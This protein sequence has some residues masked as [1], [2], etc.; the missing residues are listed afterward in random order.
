MADI[1]ESVLDKYAAERGKRLRSDQT[2]QYV[3]FRD[4]MLASMDKDPYVD[5]DKLTAEGFP[6][7]DG[8]EVKVLIAGGGML[9]IMTA[10]HLVNQAGIDS[11]D[12]VVVDKAGGFGGTWYW[13]RYPKVACDIESYCYVPLLEETNYMP[14]HRY[15]PGHEIREQLE[16]IARTSNIRGQFCTT[17]ISQSWDDQARRWNINMSRARGSG[18]EPEQLTVD[19]QFLILAG[20]IQTSPHAPKLNGLGVFAQSPGKVLMHTARWDWS[21]SGGSQETPDLTKLEGK[22]VGIVGTGATSVQ[23]APHIAKWAKETY[24]FQRTP[25]YVGPLCQKETTPADWAKVAYKPG[26]QYERMASLDAMFTGQKDAKNIVQDSWTEVSGMVAMAGH[27]GKIITPDDTEA[28]VKEMIDTD[29]PWTESMRRR[30]DEEVHDSETAQKLKAWYPG[31]CK[32]PTFHTEYLSMFNQPNVTL[33]DT[34]GKGITAYTPKGV[35]A[36]DREYELDILVLATGYTVGLVDSTPSSALNATLEGRNGR[37]LKDKWESND[38]GALY[39]VM[40]NGFPNLFFA[41]GNSGTV[42]QNAHSFYN[43]LSRVIS[44]SIKESLARARNPQMATIE[45]EKKAEDAWSE[46]VA[47]RSHWLAA[48]PTCTPGYLT[49]EGLLQTMTNLSEE[50][51]KQ[52]AIRSYWGEG[53][54]DFQKI[55]ETWMHEGQLDGVKIES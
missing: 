2:A 11:H 9:G 32:R 30:V 26:W 34:N 51:Q 29:Y 40:T 35:M 33:V 39:G 25:S 4:P 5:Y 54:L 41:S 10:Y 31:F 47:E 20:G 12:I 1:P 13:N 38:Y 16:R 28:H 49:G 48:F 22:R 43:L 23:I 8:S 37:P 45:V 17:I 14:K 55:V 7:R 19:A 21:K 53:I 27:P 15:C 18:R 24:I 6:L 42:S 50:E 44:Y 36:N 46:K 3:D 52:I